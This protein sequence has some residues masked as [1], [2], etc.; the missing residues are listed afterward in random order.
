MSCAVK[1]HNWIYDLRFYHVYRKCQA[2]GQIQRHVWNNESVYTDWAPIREENY[3][4]SEQK[5]IVRAL[6]SPASR[7]AHTLGF[8]TEQID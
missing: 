5:R 2:C 4:E 6:S 1:K 3:V 8:F 7:L